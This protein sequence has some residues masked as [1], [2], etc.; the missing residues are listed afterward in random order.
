MSENGTCKKLKE[1]Q[2]NGEQTREQV[3]K[4][5]FKTIIQWV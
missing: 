5:S 3:K 2:G 1:R 4:K